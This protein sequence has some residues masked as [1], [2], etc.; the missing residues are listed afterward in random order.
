MLKKTLKIS[1]VCLNAAI[2]LLTFGAA[3]G[4]MVNPDVTSVPAMLTLTLPLWLILTPLLLLLDVFTPWKKMTAIPAITMLLCAAPAWDY[5]P[6]RLSTASKGAEAVAQEPNRTFTVLTY[7]TLGFRY[8]K[9]SAEAD[10]LTPQ[11]RYRQL[12]E[13][14][15][16]S[17]T[18]SYMLDFRP[19]VALLQEVPPRGIQVGANI[20][21]Q[22]TDSLNMLYPDYVYSESECVIS[23]IPIKPVILRQPEETGANFAAAEIDIHGTKTLFI[24]VHLQSFQLSEDDKRLYNNLTHVNTKKE[25]SAVRH[26]LLSKLA[27]AFRARGRQAKLL[28]SQIDSLG[29][30]NVIVG[31]DFNDVSDCYAIR[32]LEKMGF[33]TVFSSCGS[34]P[35]PTYHS[36]RFYFH[37]DHILYRG[38]MSPVG[39]QRGNAKLSDH[40]PVLATFTFPE[41]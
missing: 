21:Q 41:Q 2:C 40:Y 29:Y 9:L 39:Y 13:N 8:Y 20:N 35:S 19:D 28:C 38:E 25:I 17:R 27:D 32:Q 36:N 6:L 22:Q 18:L 24:S 23:S 5:S 34:G 4:G 3:Y 16:S 14:R 31:G 11:E 10:S 30:A 1:L 7:N 26:Q 15:F 37:I 12:T 33:R